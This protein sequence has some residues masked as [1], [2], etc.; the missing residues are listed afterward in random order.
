MFLKEGDKVIIKKEKVY[1]HRRKECAKF[2]NKI[3]IITHV[4]M[5]YQAETMYR[6]CFSLKPFIQDLFFESEVEA[7]EKGDQYDYIYFISYGNMFSLLRVG[8]KTLGEK[9]NGK[10]KKIK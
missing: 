2:F 5:A 3:G 10:S 6:V 4:A 9:I 7:V 1:K 8:K